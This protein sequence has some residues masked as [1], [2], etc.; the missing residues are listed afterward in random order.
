MNPVYGLPLHEF[1]VAQRIERPPGVWEVIGS[2]PVGDYKRVFLCPML[3]TCWLFHFYKKAQVKTIIFFSFF[4]TSIDLAQD[5]RLLCTHFRIDGIKEINVT[6][7]FRGKQVIKFDNTSNLGRACLFS[8]QHKCKVRVLTS[9]TALLLGA[10][11][12]VTASKKV[13]KHYLW[14]LTPIMCHYPL[15]GKKVFI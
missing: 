9:C 2:N 3:V 1:S 7:Y 6:W 11:T 15:L 10:S 5:T 4:V 8:H 13:I 14:S 12:V